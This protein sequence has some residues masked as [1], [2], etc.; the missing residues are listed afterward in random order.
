MNFRDKPENDIFLNL[1]DSPCFII[2]DAPVSTSWRNL[3]LQ[4]G[5][6]VP[7]TDKTITAKRREDEK[8]ENE[9]LALAA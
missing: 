4:V 3:V 5:V 1:L 2:G 8:S 6:K 7:Q 9:Q